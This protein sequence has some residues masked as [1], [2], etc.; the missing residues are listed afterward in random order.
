MFN[1]IRGYFHERA[2]RRNGEKAFTTEVG[3]LAEAIRQEDNRAFTTLFGSV[4][5]S[6]FYSSTVSESLLKA[7][8]T[9]DNEPAFSTV[10]ATCSDPNIWFTEA[11]AGG[12]RGSPIL[13]NNEHILALA[14]LSGSKNIALALA[15][16]E[17]VSVDSAGFTQAIYEFSAKPVT[18]AYKS[19]HLLAREKGMHQVEKVLEERSVIAGVAHERQARKQRPSS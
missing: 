4:K 10:L 12:L 5:N 8:I 13:T 15:K 9:K 19:L 6:P 11:V 3:A 7:A 1:H 14:I 18:K 16:N 2:V 17:K